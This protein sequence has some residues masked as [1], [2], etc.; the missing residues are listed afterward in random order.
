MQS[1]CGAL[2][3]RLGGFS[4]S[5]WR[6]SVC[7]TD[8]QLGMVVKMATKGS[9]LVF[10]FYFMYVCFVGVPIHVV[11]YKYVSVFCIPCKDTFGIKKYHH[12]SK[13]E[14]YLEVNAWTDWQQE[15]LISKCGQDLAYWTHKYYTG[16]I[17]AS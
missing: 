3:S 17:I 15:D 16:H 14:S 6:V 1:P 11:W 12:A 2:L 7:Y 5:D 10:A 9:S 13:V 8:S 4:H